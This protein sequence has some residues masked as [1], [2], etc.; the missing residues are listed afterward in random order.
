M[1]AYVIPKQQLN[2]IDGVRKYLNSNLL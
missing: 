2:D 1:S